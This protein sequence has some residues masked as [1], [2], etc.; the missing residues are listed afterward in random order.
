MSNEFKSKKSGSIEI[1]HLLTALGVHDTCALVVKLFE[2]GLDEVAEHVWKESGV[3]MPWL[4]M[5][6]VTTQWLDDEADQKFIAIID[7]NRMGVRDEMS[8][9]HLMFSKNFENEP[10]QKA[11]Q[12]WLGKPDE[13]KCIE[14]RLKQCLRDLTQLNLSLLERDLGVALQWVNGNKISESFVKKNAWNIVKVWGRFR[15]HESADREDVLRW[16]SCGGEVFMERAMPILKNWVVQNQ[17][18]EKWK[19]MPRLKLEIDRYFLG[20]GCDLGRETSE[21]AKKR[22]A[23]L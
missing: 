20:L 23:V 2:K 17:N 8:D 5:L 14:D 7:R 13:K 4:S 18:D 16:K 21:K 22:K 15:D 10:W 6:K 3:S 1:S 9:R 12:V 11:T 19:K